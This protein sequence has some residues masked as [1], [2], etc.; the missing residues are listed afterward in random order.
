[1]HRSKVFLYLHLFFI[2]RI[3]KNLHTCVLLD[4]KI[5]QK[6]T[7]NI[8]ILLLQEWNYYIGGLASM[9]TGGLGVLANV[10]CLTV[11][12]RSIVSHFDNITLQYRR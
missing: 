8:K 4:L 10:V 11:I 5:T 7:L 1:M 12:C 3:S 2:S 9:V 6:F